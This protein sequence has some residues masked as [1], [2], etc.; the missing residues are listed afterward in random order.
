MK[1]FL[2]I[3]FCTALTLSLPGAYFNTH[4]VQKRFFHQGKRPHHILIKNGKVSFEI[5][6]GP[7]AVARF[8]ANEAAEILSKL[9]GTK[10]KVSAK[11]SGKSPALI[12]GCPRYAKAAGIDPAALDRDGFRIKSHDKNIIITGRDDPRRSPMQGSG[13]IQPEVGSLNGTYDFLERFAECR[14]FFPGEYGTVIPLKKELILP[15]LDI[16]DRPDWLQRRVLQGGSQA[17]MPKA[18]QKDFRRRFSRYMRTETLQ[19]P[20]CH[21][22]AFLDF[23]P[24]FAQTHPEYFALDSNGLRI[25]DPTGPRESSS[26]GQICFSSGIKEVILKDA[27]AFLKKQPASSRGI[28]SWSHSRYPRLPFFNIM[29]NDSC[30][31][32]RCK[33]CWKHFSKGEQSVSNYIWKFFTDIAREGKK[34]NLPGAF[35]TMAYESYSLVPDCDIPDNLLVMLAMR[36]PWNEKSPAMIKRDMELLKKWN[37]KLNTRPWVWT[38]PSKYAI[39]LPGVPNYAPRAAGAFYTRI[40]PYVF[41]AFAEAQSDRYFAGLL[42][43][44]VFSRIAWN[45]QTNVEKLLT[46]YHQAM[47]GPGAPFMEKVSAILEEKWLICAGEFFDTPAGPKTRQIPHKIL[48]EK[49]YNAQEL[50][51]IFHLFRQAEKASARAP[52]CLKRIRFVRQ[53]LVAPIAAERQKWLDAADAK[54]HWYAVMPEN[55]WSPGYYLLPCGNAKAEVT[56][57]VQM[58]RDKDNFYF[59][60]D[61]QEPET[62]KMIIPPRKKDDKAMWQ[63]SCVE[64]HLVPDGSTEQHYQFIITAG[65]GFA[66]IKKRNAYADYAWE[67]GAKYSVNVIPGKGYTVE[68]TV[69]RKNLPQLIPGTFRA[70]FNRNRALSKM[71][72]T[73]Y[74]AWSFF[75]KHFGDRENFGVIHL[76]PLPGKETLRETDFPGKVRAKRFLGVHW[77]SSKPFVKDSSTFVTDGSSI[78][79]QEQ[80]LLQFLPQLKPDTDYVLSCWVKLDKGGIFNIRLDEANGNIHMFPRVPLP[81]PCNWIRQEFRF[82]T[83]KSIKKRPYIRFQINKGSGWIDAPSL[84]EL[85][86]R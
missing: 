25:N 81:G 59:R 82:K 11:P 61:C 71:K 49:I 2:L 68:L 69:P 51:K 41:G 8:A 20:N 55:Q 32:C 36:G 58:K 17:V 35:T 30:Y 52:E 27:E 57:A 47:F 29:P 83:G 72:V 74:Y 42:N 37:K 65:G 53:E 18:F 31:R 38:Y 21:G 63:D 40:A 34:R 26:R 44:Y 76:A 80:Q 24:R 84:L 33:E 86:R 16:S 46:D 48:W 60:F 23:V 77:V 54:K 56:T 62:A 12:I 6:A 45:N 67:S 79:L 9:S 5:V 1:I 4:P 7:T 70:D 50:E 19:I 14:F 10:I 73:R 22:L 64:V 85:P 39:D 28:R 75:A 15:E 43:F 66:D 13:A 78:R 3:L